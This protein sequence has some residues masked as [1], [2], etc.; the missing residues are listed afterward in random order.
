ME[1]HKCDILKQFFSCYYH[2]DWT[3]ESASD[4]DV[5]SRYVGGG[6]TEKDLLE[7]SRQII[8]YTEKVS[9][10]DQELEMKMLLELGCYNRPSG[11]G[12]SARK[13]LK[14][15]TFRLE[16]RAHPR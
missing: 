2:E 5:I 11:I 9:G 13:W 3:V 15:L 16:E 6:A 1:I 7:L 4:D 12:E 10:T 14:N 8:T